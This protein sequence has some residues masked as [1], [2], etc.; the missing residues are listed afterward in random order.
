MIRSVSGVRPWVASVMV[1]GLVLAGLLM[2]VSPAR[3][4]FGITP[5]SY[6]AASSSTQAGGH[7]DLSLTFAFNTHPDL[8]LI[9]APDEDPKSLVVNLPPGVVGNPQAYPKCASSF[10]TTNGYCPADT[11]VGTIEYTLAMLPFT[12][13]SPIYNM[14]PQSGR[15][16][17][18][19]FENV[20]ITQVQVHILASVRTGDDYGITTTVPGLPGNLKPLSGNVVIWGVPSDSSHDDMRGSFLDPKTGCLPPF[21]P[22]SGTLCPSNL[23]PR[24]FFTNATQCSTPGS[25]SLTADSYQHPGQFLSPSVAIPQQMTGCDLLQFDPSISLKPDVPQAAKPSGYSVDLHIP[26]TD[27][28]TAPATAHLKKAVVTLPE[29]VTVSPSAA[30]G[31]Q[32][33]SDAQIAIHSAADPTCPN[34]A[35]IGSVHIVSPLLPGPIDGSVFQGTQTPGHLLR[36]FIVA[37]GFGVLVKLPGSIDLN[38]STGQITTTFDNNPQ[39]P[40]EDFILK[41]KGG[42]RAPLS[43]PRTCGTKTTT[44]V[45]T[46][47]SGQTVT[48]SSSFQISKDGK[49]SPCPPYGFSPAFGAQADN[50]VAGHNSSFSLFFSR[51]DDDQEFRDVSTTL[52]RGLLARVANVPLCGAGAAATGTCG[53][54]SRV[55]SV[56]TSAGPGSHPFFLSGRA[57]ITGPYKGRPFGLSLVVPAKAGPLDLGN[58]VVRAAIQVRNDGSLGVVADKLPVML[59]GIPLQVRSV[60]VNVN[61]SKFIVNP[62]NCA[63][64]R[65]NASIASIDGAIAR[66][67]SRF[68]VGDCAALPFKPKM[69][70]SVGRKGH[71]RAGASTSLTATLTQTPGQAGVKLAR[72]ALP[73]AL[74]ARLDV[75]NNA[76]TLAEFKADDCAEARAGSAVAVTPFLKHALR[77]GVYF[78]KDPSKPTGSL[79]NLM[80]ALRGQVNID[81]KGKVSIPDGTRLATTF[82][83]VPDVPI[84]RFSLRLVD[85]SHGPVGI[86]QN[87]CSSK[88]RRAMV[89]ITLRGQNGKLVQSHPPLGIHGCGTTKKH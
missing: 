80:V 12:F 62:T 4:A 57:Y 85:G 71:T 83:S 82:E 3:A 16:A 32:G 84:K 34:E 67:G 28:P 63:P 7:G 18:L 35:K 51:T 27:S 58:V 42:P 74:N 78:V 77:G 37:K 31:L 73:L 30:D 20:F 55:G 69:T 45:L 66:V 10:L 54:A 52:P 38:Q 41:F 19:A 86:A 46:S 2:G 61:R 89:S 23:P 24:P 70:I 64:M 25:V 9:N 6:T 50:P 26:Q 40:F 29:G 8:V 48:T 36:I 76:C 88:A 39:L 14:V 22:P 81:L 56:T 68:Q 44:A 5:G 33:C 75:V 47:W 79:P 11:Q 1:P 65:V 17:E 53:E 43:N 21:G 72:V 49:G 13:L 60:R 15:V 59:Q 87:L